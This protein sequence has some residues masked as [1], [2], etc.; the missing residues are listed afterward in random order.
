MTHVGV[1]PPIK[2]M[3]IE[4][5]EDTVRGRGREHAVANIHTHTVLLVIYW[6]DEAS[7]EDQT[8]S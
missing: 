3:G 5:R 4:Y 6:M 7:G 8:Q 1:P 2:L